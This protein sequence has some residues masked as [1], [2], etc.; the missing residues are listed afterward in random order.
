MICYVKKL[1]YGVTAKKPF[2]HTILLRQYTVRACKTSRNPIPKKLC[3]KS[4][5]LLILFLVYGVTALLLSILPEFQN[6]YEIIIDFQGVYSGFYCILPIIKKFFII[7][8][9]TFVKKDAG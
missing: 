8:D 3:S 9:F 4:M 7:Y 2:E 1:F 5:D 6:I